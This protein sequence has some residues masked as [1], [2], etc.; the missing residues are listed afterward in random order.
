MTKQLSS[1]DVRGT[2]TLTGL[3]G[4]SGQVLT[5]GGS[6]TT[7]T[8]TTVSGGGSGSTTAALTFGSLG[9]TAT[10]GASPWNGSTA[11]TID[12]DTTK[13]PLLASA[14]TF[15]GKITSSVATTGSSTTGAF[16]YGTLGFSD[17][18]ILASFQ[19]SANTYNQV[20]LQNT[21]AGTA[22]SAELVVSNNLASASTYQ[23]TFGMNSSGFTGSGSLNLASAV[24]LTATSGDLVLG[25]TT[26][27]AIRFVTNS[28]AT[29]AVTISS[30]G[31]LTGQSDGGFLQAFR[32]GPNQLTL[33]WATF[34]SNGN[35]Y[36]NIG[37]R[38]A[39]YQRADSLY[40]RNSLN[41]TVFG[42]GANGNA[43]TGTITT[44][45]GTTVTTFTAATASTTTVA[46]YTHA[47]TTRLVEVSQIVTITGFV[48][49][50]YFNGTYQ[51]TAIG[52]SSGAWTFTVTSP[53][54][55]FTAAGNAT[56]FGSFVLPAQSSITA[57]SAGTTGLVVDSPTGQIAN[58]QEWRNVGNTL[59]AVTPSGRIITGGLD[60]S[61]R[62]N[63]I[64]TYTGAACFAGRGLANQAADLIQLQNSSGT[65]LGGTNA[66]G[67][68]YSG[69][70]SPIKGATTLVTAA[71]TASTSAATYT[72]AATTQQVAVGQV[73][74]IAGFT[75][76]TY[77]NSPAAFGFPVT[78]VATVS[79]GTSYSFTV[80]N[81]NNNFTALGTATQFG[82]W[83]LPAQLSV[84]PTGVGTVGAIVRATS[85]QV[86]D[87]T[88]WQDSTG[89]VLAKVNAAGTI[90][91]RAGVTAASPL[92]FQSG[93]AATAAGGNVDYDGVSLYMVPN[94]TATATTL[95]GRAVVATDHIYVVASNFALQNVAT[96]QSLFGLGLAVV[97]NT[98]YRFEISAQIATGTTS[99][100]FG[101][102]LTG[103]TATLLSVHSIMTAAAPTS[104]LTAAS[105]TMAVASTTSITTA[106]VAATTSAFQILTV[107]GTFRPSVSGTFNP[108]IQFGTAP[109]AAANFTLVGSYIKV[110][111]IGATSP[112]QIG[113]WA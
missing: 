18:N 44:L 39:L 9:L 55:V 80:N 41:T 86:A 107:I 70:S 31:V 11:A 101:F 24:R 85:G 40:L 60:F 68:I 35:D 46:T 15:T 5:S 45:K 81:P 67:Q 38:N 100:T 102:G 48:N 33:A 98:Y 90:V 110:T 52:G 97:A 12:I 4:T 66:N 91:P 83:S 29:D 111:P 87:L 34:E 7:P 94:A 13:V 10:T 50:N 78:S 103:G 43:F 1:F 99:H 75:T 89:A 36:G 51:V 28:G 96:A 93:T 8:W 63:S 25:T 37:M 58:L 113:A 74:T 73:V 104:T 16:S 112:V 106:L 19:S 77:F 79:A 20:V 49:E 54:A 84:S 76:Q 65:V 82:S 95:G 27:N 108:S 32:Q 21:S 88:Q 71:T 26:S 92:T 23:G 2:L 3:S 17:T 61:A 62:I 42:V 53:A 6:G 64:P 47:G 57:S 105:P 22:A 14:P 56:Q 72:Y 109:G 30:A 69:A 59:M